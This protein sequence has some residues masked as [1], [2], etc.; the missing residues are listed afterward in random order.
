MNDVHIIILVH[1]KI[2]SV[3]HGTGFARQA[4]LSVSHYS[5]DIISFGEM[6]YKYYTNPQS[7]GEK[8]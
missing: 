2:N 3:L 5:D 6:L 4:G 1:Y 8:N 7:P